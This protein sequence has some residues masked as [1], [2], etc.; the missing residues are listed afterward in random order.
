MKTIIVPADFSENSVNA[1]I[2]AARLAE[3]L[4]M[5][6]TLLHALP[7]PLSAGEAVFPPSSYEDDF[8]QTDQLMKQLKVKLEGSSKAT[9]RYRI[10]MDSF[11][12]EI[13]RLN[14]RQDIFAMIMGMSGSTAAEAFLFGS[15]SLMAATHFKYPLVVIPPDCTFN[16]V[17]KVGLAC[18]MLNVS[19]TLPAKSIIDFLGD[20]DARLHILHVAKPE[21]QETAQIAVA[22]RSIQNM[23]QSLKP[24]MHVAKHITVKEGLEQFVQ[25]NGIDLLMVI[26]KERTFVERVFHKSITK[27][28]VLHSR[29]PVMILHKQ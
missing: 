2:Y 24:E 13:E 17:Q 11:L 22:S 29:V 26:P 10:I 28:M 23:L 4:D 9:V 6:I 16:G 7:L 14:H 12:A 20:F 25:L 18:D 1:A 19:E 3:Q 5:H 27:N 21:A 8:Q 15:F